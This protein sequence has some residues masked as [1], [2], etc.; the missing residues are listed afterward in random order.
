MIEESKHYALAIVCGA[1]RGPKDSDLTF[2]PASLRDFLKA[3]D[4]PEQEPVAHLWQHSET[5]RTRIVMPDQIITA[6]A[7]WHVV[8]PLYLTP[9]RREWVGLT[10]EE[11]KS[12]PQWFPSHETAAVLPLIRAIEAK[13]REKNT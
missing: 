5:G 10:D 8:G 12:L 9:P 4:Q 7:T 2:S 11:V 13:L 1:K 3:L 6:D